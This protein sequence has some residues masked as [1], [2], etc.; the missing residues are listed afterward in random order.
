MLVVIVHLLSSEAPNQEFPQLLVLAAV[1]Y[2]KARWCL[3]VCAVALVYKISPQVCELDNHVQ[4][5][6][7]VLAKLRVRGVCFRAAGAWHSECLRCAEKLLWC[8]AIVG[9]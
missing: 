8:A 7:Q 4:E 9:S 6:C 5:V 3:C 2:V 1:V